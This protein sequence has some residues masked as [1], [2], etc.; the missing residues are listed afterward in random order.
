MIVSP[1]FHGKFIRSVWMMSLETGVVI[2]DEL[3]TKLSRQL[4]YSTFFL[5]NLKII[6]QIFH[7]I[8][9]KSTDVSSM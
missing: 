3:T 1:T 7:S 8:Q 5:I 6:K 2:E 9:K 4:K